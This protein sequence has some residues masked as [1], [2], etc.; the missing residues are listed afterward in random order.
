MPIICYGQ[1]PF[2]IFLN[3][4]LFRSPGLSSLFN[5]TGGFGHCFNFHFDTKSALKPS[6]IF[7]FGS[8]FPVAMSL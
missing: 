5:I 8:P 4:R 3:I 1:I 7:G 6:P 2:R